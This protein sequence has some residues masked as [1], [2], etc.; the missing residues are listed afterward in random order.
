M[1]VDGAQGEASSSTARIVKAVAGGGQDLRPLLNLNP[2]A[3]LFTSTR[4]GSSP[5]LPPPSCPAQRTVRII[6][7]PT[8]NPN[9]PAGS[10]TIQVQLENDVGQT[11]PVDPPT[12]VLVDPSSTGSSIKR[13]APLET[14]DPR[15][16]EVEQQQQQQHQQHQHQHQQQDKAPLKRSRVAE[17]STITGTPTTTTTTTTTS[18]PAALGLQAMMVRALGDLAA[19]KTPSFDVKALLYQ[20]ADPVA[21]RTVL[22]ALHALLKP[23]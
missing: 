18:R 20:R 2:K 8:W 15:T 6:R 13:T 3:P 22:R 9:D 7:P 16:S 21:L 11:T 23:E 12:A 10:M 1:Q 14:P 5:S 4:P 17:G 19:G